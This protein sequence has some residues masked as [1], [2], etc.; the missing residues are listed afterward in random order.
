MNSKHL[1]YKLSTTERLSAYL[2]ARARGDTVGVEEVVSASPRFSL[3]APD[4]YPYVEALQVMMSVH[5]LSQIDRLLGFLGLAVVWKDNLEAF[6]LGSHLAKTYLV[7]EAACKGVCD[8]YGFDYEQSRAVLLS[9]SH[10]FDCI[11]RSDILQAMAQRT[12]EESSESILA[13]ITVEQQKREYKDAIQDLV[14]RIE[15][16]MA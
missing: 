7:T 1:Y 15:S 16:N 6:A 13:G 10:A 12:V 14:R 3:S 9:E 11:H 4:F 2:R 5:L 8:E